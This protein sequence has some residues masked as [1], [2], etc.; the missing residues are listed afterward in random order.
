MNE[1]R[2]WQLRE[3]K[4]VAVYEPDERWQIRVL[5]QRHNDDKQWSVRLFFEDDMRHTITTGV[6][7][8][9]EAH[10]AMLA[11]IRYHHVII[12]QI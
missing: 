10:E 5:E 8:P 6:A 1:L 11:W 4:W 3:E 9:D 12:N 2:N 7:D